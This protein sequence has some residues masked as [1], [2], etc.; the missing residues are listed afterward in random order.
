MKQPEKKRI[1]L[2][3]IGAIAALAA[4]GA[5]ASGF[6]LIEQ[7]GSSMGNAF[8]GAAAAAEDAST[9]FFNPAGL[10]RLSTTQAVTALHA[11]NIRTHFNNNA[12]APALGQQLGSDGGNAG[13]LAVIPNFYLGVPLT[14]QIN[15]GLG[16]NAPFGLKT[17]YDS[18][19]IG[20]FQAIKSKVTTINV[21]P[22]LSFKVNDQLSF[23]V[24]ADWQRLDAEFTNTVN[25]TG[26]VAQ[27]LQAL[28]RAGQIPAAAVPSLIAANA[29]LQG[30]TRIDG[31]DSGWGF[32]A[33]VLFN[34]TPQTR[35][36]A[37]YRSSIKYTIRG[38]VN[39]N[40]PTVAP[41][42][43]NPAAL[44]IASVGQAGGPLASGPVRL[45]IK[46]PDS[47]SVS[48]FHQW[49]SQ[50]DLLADVSWTG[51]S[52]IQ[53]LRIVRDSGAALSVTPEQWR[54]TWRYSLGANYHLNNQWKLRAGVAYDQT[55]VPGSTRTPR[56]P[57]NNRTWVAVGAQY[58]FSPAATVDVG[59]T[60]L[61]VKDADINQNGGSTPS[62]GL[63][64]GSYDSKIDIFSLQLAYNF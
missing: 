41:S 10:S 47:A 42:P 9:L 58:R 61:F 54:D 39:F 53:E 40:A 45:D 34:I 17:E 23:G 31:D 11:I 57:D 22:A 28:A 35:V 64:N 27:G 46:V 63:I 4:G 44:I 16:L 30:N 8:A 3:M 59:Y 52:K 21:N 55:P 56:L 14:N 60:H 51:W 50:W 49:D 5:A 36:G 19:W 33:G 25:Y 26:V 48:L 38:N 15:M 6:A 1:A 37:S 18:D 29:G 7:S 62:F 32:N 24:G 2:T 12:S 20:R 13:D 43:R